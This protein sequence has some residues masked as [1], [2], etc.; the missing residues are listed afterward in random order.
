VDLFQALAGVVAS[1][2]QEDSGSSSSLPAS[3]DPGDSSV[4]LEQIRIGVEMIRTGFQLFH[5]SMTA[6]ASAAL[7]LD[8]EANSHDGE[9]WHPNRVVSS[10]ESV[11]LA[12]DNGGYIENEGDLYE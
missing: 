4:P 5:T 6:M 7:V 2:Q 8:G 12:S 1:R 10:K 9:Q 3:S 11:Q